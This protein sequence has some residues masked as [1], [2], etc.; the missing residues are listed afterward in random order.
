LPRLLGWWQLS[1]TY[2]D[3]DL[4]PTIYN[5]PYSDL[6]HLSPTGPFGLNLV[7]EHPQAPV[8]TTPRQ[9]RYITVLADYVEQ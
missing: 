4:E 6:Q 3:P 1:Y 5:P 2:L 9:N 7:E 8:G